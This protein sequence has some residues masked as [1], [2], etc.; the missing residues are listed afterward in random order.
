MGDDNSQPRRR[1]PD[2]RRVSDVRQTNDMN[3]ALVTWT[4]QLNTTTIL[5]DGFSNRAVVNSN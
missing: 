3:P 5:Q 4:S 2:D 1:T